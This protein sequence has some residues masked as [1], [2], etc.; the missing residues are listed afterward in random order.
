MKIIVIGSVVIWT[1]CLETPVT[2]EANICSDRLKGEMM[3]TKIRN[4]IK[5]VL[6]NN[7]YV[8]NK[9]SFDYQNKQGELER[10]CSR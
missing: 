8:L 4:I 10:K 5:K 7:W 3:N 9:Y 6:S 1:V 2:K